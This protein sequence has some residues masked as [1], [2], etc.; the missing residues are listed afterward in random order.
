M[1]KATPWSK[2]I[3]QR[4]LYLLGHI[5]RLAEDT[6]ARQA[7]T[8]MIRHSKRKCGRPRLTWIALIKKDLCELGIEA[9]DDMENI[10]EMAADRD[11]WRRRTNIT[12][13]M[14]YGGQPS[15]DL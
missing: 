11:V 14:H 1:T 15:V 6:P 13:S 12:G 5:C 7:L 4:R 2:I 10:I 9:E 3:K 8:E